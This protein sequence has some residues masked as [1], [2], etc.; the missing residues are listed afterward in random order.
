MEA[1]EANS[2]MLRFKN[3][4]ENLEE[5]DKKFGRLAVNVQVA[6]QI[7]RTDHD[8]V[9]IP[10]RSTIVVSTSLWNDLQ[11]LI[12]KASTSGMT[13]E[14]RKHDPKYTFKVQDFKPVASDSS[15]DY[16]RPLPDFGETTTIGSQKVQTPNDLSQPSTLG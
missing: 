3:L 7:Q 4:K 12:R 9:Q 1:F 15:T 10:I 13:H 8:T 16:M 2:I 5:L 14:L 11:E 6:G